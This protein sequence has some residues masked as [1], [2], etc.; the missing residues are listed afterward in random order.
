MTLMPAWPFRLCFG[1]IRVDIHYEEYAKFG[2]SSVWILKLSST[3]TS[4][5]HRSSTSFGHL[6]KHGV[7]SH[8]IIS[9]IATLPLNAKP[10]Q[11][12]PK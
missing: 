12:R 7:M 4:T 2:L 8:H 1:A 6:P 9:I 3:N 11:K 10:A 5:R